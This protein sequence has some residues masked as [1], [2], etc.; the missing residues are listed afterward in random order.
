MRG[1]RDTDPSVTERNQRISAT[2]GK[3]ENDPRWSCVSRG[4][5]CAEVDRYCAAKDGEV[6]LIAHSFADFFKSV[7]FVMRLARVY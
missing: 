7:E 2:R 6:E 5:T 1:R 4:G 3:K